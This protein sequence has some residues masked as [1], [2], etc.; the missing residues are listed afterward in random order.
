MSER[1]HLHCRS[2]AVKSRKKICLRKKEKGKE[3][4]LK[5]LEKSPVVLVY[6]PAAVIALGDKIVGGKQ[7]LGQ[8]IFLRALS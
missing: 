6:D 7:S 2:G 3:Y 8:F 1:P 4:S 5:Y